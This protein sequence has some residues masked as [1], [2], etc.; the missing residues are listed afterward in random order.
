ML[1]HFSCVRLFA[2]LLTTALQAPPSLGLSRQQYW[3]GSP[4]TGVGRRALLQGSFLTQGSNPCLF[5]LLYWQAS[6]VPLV[7]QGR[8]YIASHSFHNVKH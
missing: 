7:P 3:S 2:T 6:S 8:P 5:H 4:C 1:S